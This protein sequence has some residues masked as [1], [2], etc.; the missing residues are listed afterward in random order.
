MQIRLYIDEEHTA[1]DIFRFAVFFYSAFICVGVVKNTLISALITTPREVVM[2]VEL[3]LDFD[4]EP[5]LQLNKKG[6]W[7]II[8]FISGEDSTPPPSTRQPDITVTVCTPVKDM[9]GLQMVR[10]VSVLVRLVEFITTVA[11]RS[12]IQQLVKQW[13]TNN[14]IDAR[15]TIDMRM[16]FCLLVE[17]NN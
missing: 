9:L 11:H 2:Q 7:C 3:K 17:K 13:G 16:A 6:C 15:L 8:T 10:K 14:T 4:V 1:L 5:R 12:A